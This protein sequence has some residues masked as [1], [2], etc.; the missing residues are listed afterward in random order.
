MLPGVGFGADVD[1]PGRCGLPFPPGVDAANWPQW[2]QQH[3]REI[4]SRLRRGEE[5]SLVN[6]IL[7]GVSFTTRPRVM[8]GQ[9]DQSLIDAR[10]HDFLSA[11]NSSTTSERIALLRRLAPDEQSIRTNISRYLTER[12]QYANVL[13]RAS[14]GDPV[15]SQLYKNRGLSIDTNFR[16]NFAIEKT[17]ASLKSRGTLTFVSRAAIIGPGLDFTDKDSGFDY[18]PLQ[19]LQPFAL[20]DSLLRLGLAK[21]P[22]LR[23]GVFDISPETLGHLNRARNKPYTVQLVLD[24]TRPW[25]KNTLDYWNRF[26][27][28]IG[29]P[30]PPLPA[31]KQIQNVERR[32]V[33]IRPAIVNA[34]DAHELNIVVQHADEK[35]DL[36]VG[37]NVFVYYD[38][39]DQALAMLNLES[40]LSPGGILLS[41]TSLPECPGELLHRIASEPVEYSAAPGDDDL[42]EIYSNS[43]LRRSLAPR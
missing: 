42:V 23:V 6:F 26:G 38:A 13:D 5:D 8:P 12:R 2:I 31:P 3:D 11:L 18:Y 37:T 36:I 4:R 1:I 41:N 27:D 17:L 35:Y 10:I 16:P 7:F 43:A 40:M 9:P 22:D 30:V 24:K 29:V 33:R 34:L 20:I 25:Q 14:A 15:A 28:R 19:T 32:A 21:I 39:F